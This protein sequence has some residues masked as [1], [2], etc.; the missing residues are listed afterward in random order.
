MHGPRSVIWSSLAV[1]TLVLVLRGDAAVVYLPVELDSPGNGFG[2]A[3]NNHRE[4]VGRATMGSGETHAALWRDGQIMDLGT[5][6]GGS[7]SEAFAINDAGQV[8]GFGYNDQS[9]CTAFDG[10][11]HA[12]LWQDGTM[13]DLGGLDPRFQSYAYSI[14]E[15]G[16]IA[17]T[18]ATA[19]YPFGFFHA[20]VWENGTQTDL[21]RPESASDAAALGINARGDAVGWAAVN[22]QVLPFLWSRGSA[23]PLPMPAGAQGA[24]AEKINNRGQIVGRG[25]NHPLLWTNGAVAEL[26]DIPGAARSDAY[27]LNDSGIVVG[28]SLMSNS[29]FVAVRW[30][31]GSPERLPAVA[32]WTESNARG[33]NA[34]GDVAGAAMTPRGLRA[35][36]WLKQ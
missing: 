17:G 35:V 2:F 8:V 29:A 18:S 32:G 15:R 9:A 12:F 4:V 21:G 30:L 26:P 19:D 31:Q 14:N 36:V 25:S 24:E 20:V 13:T 33:I 10:C 7:Y 34:Q 16:A 23:T 1:L 6:P 22:G 3:V 28:D 11:W 5:L 27:D